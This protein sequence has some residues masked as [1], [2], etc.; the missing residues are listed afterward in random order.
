[1]CEVAVDKAVSLLL[2]VIVLLSQPACQTQAQ[3]AQQMMT[4]ALAAS[5]TT[6]GRAKVWDSYQGSSVS[7][8]WGYD[9]GV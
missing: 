1:M 9:A 4:V 6:A 5:V 3:A 8:G 7:S 2:L